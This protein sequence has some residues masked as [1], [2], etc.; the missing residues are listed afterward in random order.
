VT[1]PDP[2]RPLSSGPSHAG[3]QAIESADPDADVESSGPAVDTAT[4]EPVA[5]QHRE[6]GPAAPTAEDAGATAAETDGTDGTDATEVDEDADD[7]PPKRKSFWRELPVLILVA[8]VLA[9]L[10]KTFLVQAFF[11]PSESMENTLLVG[12]RVLVNKLAY[13]FGEVERGDVVV[14]DGRGS[15]EPKK[16]ADTGGNSIGDALRAIA[17]SFGLAPGTESDYIK[18]VIGVGGDHVVCCDTEGR[19]T[20]NDAPLD[21]EDYLFPGDE[22]STNSFDITVPE[23]RI[24]VMGDHRSRSE[25]SRA[26]TGLPGGG[27][28]SVDKVIGRAFVKV[29]P[30]GRWDTMP[31]PAAFDD[32]PD[33]PPP[34]GS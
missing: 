23:G 34:D 33:A 26:H 25:D 29:W 1:S 19:I 28:V 12:D 30:I 2:S 22:P 11:I 15:F 20:I 21:P 14:F 7:E 18:R 4:D 27:T 13:R 31:R 5:A 17:S 24:W 3:P 16:T 32:I 8:L 9:F 6:P 10:I